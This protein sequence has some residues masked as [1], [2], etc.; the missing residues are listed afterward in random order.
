[1]ILHTLEGHGCYTDICAMYLD[2]RPVA[3]LMGHSSLGKPSFSR[4]LHPSKT[5]FYRHQCQWEVLPGFHPPEVKIACLY[6]PSSPCFFFP[7]E[8]RPCALPALR[9]LFP[10]VPITC[11]EPPRRMKDVHISY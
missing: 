8:A 11:H 7:L 3:T 5:F 4:L 6:R 10:M 1:M 9:A 2:L